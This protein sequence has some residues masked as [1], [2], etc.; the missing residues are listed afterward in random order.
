MT[1]RYPA[2]SDRLLIL[3][4]VLCLGLS[5]CDRGEVR[6]RVFG[7]VTFQGQ[8]VSEGT[9]VFG[10]NEKGV[11]MTARLKP[12]GSYEIIMAQGVG[13]PVGK[14]R[15][16]VCPPMQLAP[17]EP[18]TASP[19]AAVKLYA[20]IPEKYRSLETSGLTLTVKEGENPFDIALAP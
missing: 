18:D 8:A 13:L 19:A 12:D 11:H 16:R 9:V 14:Y 5:G 17:L 7:K 3:V 15:V 1:A 10:N 20:N 4:V 2:T 6:G